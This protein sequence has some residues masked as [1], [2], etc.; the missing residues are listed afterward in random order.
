MT[1]TSARFLVNNTTNIDAL[2]KS[3]SMYLAVK[4]PW[5]SPPNRKYATIT[6][7]LKYGS[8]TSNMTDQSRG[9]HIKSSRDDQ[10]LHRFAV[11][12]TEPGENP[13]DV[14]YMGN[15]KSVMG[16]NIFEWLLPLQRSPCC[17]HESMM[18]D[19]EIGPLLSTLQRRYGVTMERTGKA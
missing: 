7:P 1:A 13:W 2:K 14:G 3:S 4:I 5:N 19:Y 17:N 15:I 16:N 18:S 12:A 10:A 6:Y 8:E 9:S 11:L